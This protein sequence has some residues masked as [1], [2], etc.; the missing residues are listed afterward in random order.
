MKSTLKGM[1]EKSLQAA[2]R[3]PKRI[4]LGATSETF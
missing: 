2:C 4:D 1:A 3:D